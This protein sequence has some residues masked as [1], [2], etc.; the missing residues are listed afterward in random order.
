M[1]LSYFTYIRFGRHYDRELFFTK[2]GD[3]LEEKMGENAREYGLQYT[4]FL[5]PA[6]SVHLDSN[7]RFEIAETGNKSSVYIFTAV[8]VFI[9]LLA[10][11]NF[12]NLTT[13]RSFP[14]R[15]CIINEHSAGSDHAERL[16]EEIVCHDY[17]AIGL[18]FERFSGKKNL[19]TLESGAPG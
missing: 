5:Q 2:L 17:V 10:C 6:A 1:S 9:L 13:A 4:P 11:I 3:L 14:Y 8:A 7:S 18:F 12:I 16:I 15:D 19:S